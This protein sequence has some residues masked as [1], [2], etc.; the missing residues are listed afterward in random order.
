MW[1]P[2]LTIAVASLGAV[3]SAMMLIWK[4]DPVD[5]VLL[6]GVFAFM[7]AVV[8]APFALAIYIARRRPGPAWIQP[9][10]LVTV[11]A[12]C[13]LSAYGYVSFATATGQAKDPLIFAG[14]PI[15]QLVAVGLVARLAFW[16]D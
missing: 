6:Y 13:A 4:A 16:L 5:H 3:F 1:I 2:R 11:L 14:V 15:Y 10:M 7:I 12:A 9:L 8:C